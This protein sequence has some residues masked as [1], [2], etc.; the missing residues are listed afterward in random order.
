MK[1]PC[2]LGTFYQPHSMRLEVKGLNHFC[3]NHGV[4][5]KMDKAEVV[6]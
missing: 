3:M 1:N 6:V 2:K 4:T 5:K